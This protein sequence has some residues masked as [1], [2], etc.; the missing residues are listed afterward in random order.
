LLFSNA[1]TLTASTAAAST[2]ALLVGPAQGMIDGIG[3]AT[4]VVIALTGTVTMNGGTIAVTLNADDD[5]AGTNVITVGTVTIPTGAKQGDKFVIDIPAN[6]DTNAGQ[7]A[8]TNRYYYLN[9][10][11]NAITTCTLT[12]WLSLDDMVQNNSVYPKSGYTI[13]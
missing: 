11:P 1:Q 2:N 7:T 13:K 9:Y 5:N 8:T 3:E 10:V 4:E 6:D 12:A